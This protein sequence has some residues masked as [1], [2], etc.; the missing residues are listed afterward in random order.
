MFSVQGLCW[1][2]SSLPRKVGGG[3][4]LLND[5]PEAKEAGGRFGLACALGKVITRQTMPSL[6]PEQMAW[7]V[8]TAQAWLPLPSTPHSCPW[9]GNTS[10]RFK[11]PWMC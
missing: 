11:T 8:P 9:V 5:S 1:F 7:A 6:S 3:V 2:S 10:E 4:N